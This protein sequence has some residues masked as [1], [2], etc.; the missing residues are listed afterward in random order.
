MLFCF[1]TITSRECCSGVC[2]LRALISRVRARGYRFVSADQCWGEASRASTP[3]N[4][5]ADAWRRARTVPDVCQPTVVPG[6]VYGVGCS[7]R[8]VACY[9]PGAC[10]SPD[11]SC[12]AGEWECGDG[13]QGGACTACVPLWMPAPPA[14]GAV[15]DWPDPDSCSDVPIDAVVAGEGDGGDTDPYNMRL[16]LFAGNALS[17]DWLQTR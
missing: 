12:S 1:E 17:F 11:G 2:A 13:C 8:S 6:Q 7:N 4:P 3:L 16:V 10:C 5:T 14:T 15:L 9:E